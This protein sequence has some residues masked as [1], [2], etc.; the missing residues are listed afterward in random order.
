MDALREVAHRI[1]ALVTALAERGV[2]P[3]GAPFV[4]YLVLG[5]G[6]TS[7]TVEAGVP[8]HRAGGAG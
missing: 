5:P 6:M 8:G 7:L 3:A 2:E 4:R 1:A